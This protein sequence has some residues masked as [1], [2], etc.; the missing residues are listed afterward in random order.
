VRVGVI[1]AGFGQKAHVPG[2]K[3]WP[4]ATVLA[5]CDIARNIAE[6]AAQELDIPRVFTDYNE[7]VKVEELDLVTVATPPF[8]HYPM[9]MA[10]LQAG[11]HVL[12]E[13]P[14]ALNAV[15]ALGMYRR[16]EEAGVV[17][18]VD[19]ELRFNPTR[20]RMK[21]LIAEGYIGRLRHVLLT[22]FTSF[23][24]S[25]D[26][27]PWTWWS[28][29]ETGGGRLGADGSHQI[30]QLRWWFGEIDGVSSR[31]RTFVTERKLPGSSEVRRVDS[32]DFTSLLV[33]FDS[34]A[35]GV[36]C[37]SSVV[38]HARGN[39]VEVYG[40][41]GSLALDADNRLWG[42]RRGEK[43]FEDLTVP[44]PLASRDGIAENVWTRSFAHLARH[45]IDTIRSG[46]E[47]QQG[48][49]FLDGLRCQAVLDAAKQSWDEERWVKIDAR[50]D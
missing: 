34:G 39:R 30:D 35:E 10:A 9:V 50:I 5:I 46:G 14:L 28:Q 19:H 1:G 23:Q 44:D 11:K 25:A 13:K 21:E 20:R 36:I 43:D 32:D 17:H 7:M 26:S 41:E 6:S 38:R 31:G 45:L 33:H 49:T 27:A 4:D 8:L 3:V 29:R 42:A 18:L 22:T 47:V 16:A 15:E 2:F 24:A 12:C 37:L 48:A 40:D